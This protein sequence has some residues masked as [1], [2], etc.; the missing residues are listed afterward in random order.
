MDEDQAAVTAALQRLLLTRAFA[1]KDSGRLILRFQASVMDRYRERGASL[2]RTRT[3]GRVSFPGRW[4]LDVGIAAE[5]TEVQ[6]PFEDLIDRLPE[7]ERAHWVEHL[8]IEPA[9]FNFLR[10]R[11]AGAACIDDGEAQQWT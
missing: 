5:D 2:I 8:V 10:M 1:S 4:S 6:V 9:S 11:L 7:A 3:V